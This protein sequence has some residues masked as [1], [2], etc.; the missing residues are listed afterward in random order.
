MILKDGILSYV[1]E[2]DANYFF[3]FTEGHIPNI[4]VKALYFDGKN[5]LNVQSRPIFYDYK[6]KELLVDIKADKQEYKPGDTVEVEVEVRDTNGN[7][8]S[9]EVNLSVVDEAFFAI[10]DQQVDTLG[11]LYR[12]SFTS[13]ILSEYL[14]YKPLDINIDHRTRRRR[15]DQSIRQ[16]FKDNACLLPLK[17]AATVKEKQVLRFR[18]T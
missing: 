10:Q 11:S 4:Y 7:P 8:C 2:S 5:I 9:A 14:S 3:N 13:G 16:L 15:R 18:I 1:I 6:E 17:Q 12:Y